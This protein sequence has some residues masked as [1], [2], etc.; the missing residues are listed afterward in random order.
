LAGL[1]G[2]LNIIFMEEYFG[3]IVIQSSK[4]MVFFHDHACPFKDENT[5][6]P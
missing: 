6:W 2:M 1:I 5:N 3:K 4:R